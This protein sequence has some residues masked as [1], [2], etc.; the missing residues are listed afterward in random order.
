VQ[1]AQ[2][3]HARFEQCRELPREDGEE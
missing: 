2:Q 3:R 1:T